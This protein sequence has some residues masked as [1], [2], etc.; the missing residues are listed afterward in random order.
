MKKFLCCKTTAIILVI[1]TILSIGCYAYMLARPISYGMGY[2]N[3]TVYDGGVFEGTMKFYP[4]N[5]MLNSNSNF[6]EEMESRYY[7]K[8]GYV[9]FTLA[10]TDEQYEKEVASINENF[11]AA[12][13]MPF[14]SDK[15]NAFQLVATEGDGF[16]TVYT[17]KSA[18]TFAIVG[19]VIEVALIAL[20][21]TA[22]ILGKKRQTEAE[23]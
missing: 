22:W 23:E 10:Q 2:H 14:Y 6:D 18:I 5:K 12:L 16:T 11:D 3:E 7:Y 15:I 4:D 9:F 21:C 13:K 8:D 19:G 17:C 20:S 1:L